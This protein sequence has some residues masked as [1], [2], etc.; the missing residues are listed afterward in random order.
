MGPTGELTGCRWLK[1]NKHLRYMWIP[2][3]DTVV[4]VKCNPTTRTTA[5]GPGWF[6]KVH[7]EDEKLRPLRELLHGATGTAPAA[8]L[9]AT[10]LRDELIAANPLDTDWIK[11]VNAAEAEF[12]KRNSGYRVGWSD[13]L[14]G[15]DCGGQ[16]WVLEVAFPTDTGTKSTQVWCKVY[17]LQRRVPRRARAQ[18][19]EKCVEVESC[20]SVLRWR[21]R[22]RPCAG[23][24][25]PG[26]CDAFDRAGADCGA[27]AD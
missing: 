1:Q 27:G 6:G 4:V 14:L 3:T 5:P 2:Y 26:R 22:L 9:S 21:D 16:Q 23:S 7:S 13:E 18:M 25:I 12:W 11:R 20:G 19:I 17:R 15:F 10:Q 24:A 8:E